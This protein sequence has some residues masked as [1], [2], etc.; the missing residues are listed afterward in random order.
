M[1]QCGN[2]HV[3]IVD[4]LSTISVGQRPFGQIALVFFFTNELRRAAARG[5]PPHS[6]WQPALAG[7]ASPGA[8]HQKDPWVEFEVETP[9]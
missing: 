5:A 6:R 9:Y 7:L 3:I 8:G 2:R 1:R 4:K